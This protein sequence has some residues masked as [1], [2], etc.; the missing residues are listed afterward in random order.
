MCSIAHPHIETIN[1]DATL[2]VD[3]KPFLMRAGETHN[4]TGSSLTWMSRAWDKA[5]EL[6]MNTLFVAVTWELV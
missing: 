1:G 6:G 4:S 2:V 3:G 5:D